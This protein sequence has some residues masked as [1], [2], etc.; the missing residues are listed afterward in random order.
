MGHILLGDF[1]DRWFK[2]HRVLVVVAAAVLVAAAFVALLWRGAPGLDA[3]RLRGLTP[4]ERQSAIDAIRGRLLQLG[5]GLVIGGGLVYTGLTFRLN[6]ESQI[7]ERYTKAIDLVGSERLDVKLGAIYTL[8][9]IMID[10]GRD[11]PTI[12]EVLAAYIREHAPR[13]PEDDPVIPARRD[14]TRS[15]PTGRSSPPT[16]AASGYVRP[17][18]DP[19]ESFVVGVVVA[20]DD[21]TADHAG[22]L[23]MAGVVSAVEREVPQGGELGLD[24]V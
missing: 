13:A 22:L 3:S 12:V 6:R 18:D 19:A 15:A 1:L 7:T 16:S 4:V 10:S 20:P 24:P 23:F 8:E 17:V 14:Q 11:H 2:R 5:A 9:R 21:V